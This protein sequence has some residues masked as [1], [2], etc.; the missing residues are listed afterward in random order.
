MLLLLLFLSI[1]LLM[2]FDQFQINAMTREQKVMRRNELNWSNRY[3][4]THTPHTYTYLYLYIQIHSHSLKKFN[5]NA[6]TNEYNTS[7]SDTVSKQ[8]NKQNRIKA[9]QVYAQAGE[10][11]SERDLCYFFI[12]YFCCCF[13]LFCRQ[14]NLIKLQNDLIAYW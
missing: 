11:V 3:T 13:W 14:L 8:A 12:L 2:K 7:Q 1:C 6:W 5:S 9:H 4:H 10:R